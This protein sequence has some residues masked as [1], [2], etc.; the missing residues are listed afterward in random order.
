MNT[1]THSIPAD[2]VEQLQRSIHEL[3]NAL[4]PILANAQLARVMI[5][6]S[7]ADVREAMDDV[8]EAAGRANK[9]VADLREVARRLQD[10]IEAAD[11]PAPEIHDG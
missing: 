3:N 4:T 11:A 5:D 9:L 6:P 2:L 7:A 10:T 8:V 1:P